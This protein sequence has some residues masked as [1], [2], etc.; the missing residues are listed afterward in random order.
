MSH[1]LSLADLK[2]GSLLS[3]SPHG[4][5]ES[6]RIAREAML[7]LKSDKFF[8][9]PPILMS[10][11]ISDLI[12]KGIGTLPF[13]YFF[14]TEPILVPIPNSALIKEDTLWVLNV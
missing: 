10:Q 5:S 1:T 14:D 2:F 6:E 7:L 11:F 3:Y 13:A 4:K 12:V 8:S 9:D